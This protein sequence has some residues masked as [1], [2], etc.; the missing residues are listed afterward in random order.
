MKEYHLYMYLPDWFTRANDS[1]SYTIAH[2]N[3]RIYRGLTVDTIQACTLSTSLFEKGYR[4][5]IH[6]KPGSSFEITLGTCERTNRE[7]KMGHNLLNLLLSGEF[8]LYKPTDHN[9][10]IMS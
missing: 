5:F 4:V 9:K 3:E 2:T 6:D 8:E 7:I 1:C 10:T